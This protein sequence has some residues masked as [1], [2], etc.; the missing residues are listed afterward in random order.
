MNCLLQDN[1]SFTCIIMSAVWYIILV[2]TDFCNKV[3]Q[4]SDATL[5]IEVSNIERLLSQVVDLRNS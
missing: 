4:A 1:S 2:P 3:I 5:D